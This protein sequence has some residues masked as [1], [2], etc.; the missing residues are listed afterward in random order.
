[1]NR[2]VPLAIL[3][4]A[5]AACGDDPITT[6]TLR[7]TPLP[8]GD[9][10]ELDVHD[11]SLVDLVENH[12]RVEPR[13]RTERE[14]VTGEIGADGVEYQI[15]FT[16]TG[17]DGPAADH[18]DAPIRHTYSD[19]DGN[20]LAFG[21][22]NVWWAIPGDGDVTITLRHLAPRDGEPT[23]TAQTADQVKAG[24]FDAIGGSTD[25]TVTIPVRVR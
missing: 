19:S 3:I 9:P 1:M 7:I 13:F 2:I 23:K 17:V 25:A 22:D 18:P 11:D 12:Y 21:L 16:G 8:G 5:A 14:D 4:L 24:G 10:F 15:F 6:I 20:G